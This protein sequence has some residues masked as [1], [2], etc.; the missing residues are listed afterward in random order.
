MP[1]NFERYAQKGN[2]FLH[3]LA[4]ELGD[5][6]NTENAGRILRAVLKT[7]RNHLTLEESFQLLAQLPMSLKS[8]Y[9]DGWMPQ[10]KFEVSRKKN[11]FI[12]EVLQHQNPKVW[13]SVSEVREGEK[14]IIAV[15]KTLKKY[16]SQGEF[17]D[18]EAV[19]PSQLKKLLRDSIYI[20]KLTVKLVSEK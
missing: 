16:I 7:L 13:G 2:Q 19:L 1:H 8:M 3:E 10:K 11:D 17:E 9:V 15:F 18:M 14:T 5:K 20:K 12:L 4:D 6:K